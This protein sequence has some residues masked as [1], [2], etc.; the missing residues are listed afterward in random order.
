MTT[1]NQVNENQIYAFAQVDDKDKEKVYE[2][3]H[4][5]KSRFGWSQRD[6][7]DLSNEQNRESLN[8]SK[9]LF[10]TR[11]KKGDWIVHVN[12]PTWGKCVAAM[13][14]GEY[15]FDEG[16]AVE[17]ERNRDFRHYIPIDVNSITEFDRRDAYGTINLAPRGRQHTVYAKADFLTFID[18]IKSGNKHH[19]DDQ[20]YNNTRERLGDITRLINKYHRGK[21]L[22]GFLAKVFRAIPGVLDVKENGKRWGADHGADL[23]VEYSYNNLFLGVKSSSIINRNLRLV[24]QAKSYDGTYTG[25]GEIEQIKEGIDKYNAD[26]GLIINTADSAE[27]LQK[28]LENEGNENIDAIIGEDVASFVIGASP[29]VLFDYNRD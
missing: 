10:L 16:I 12:S 29:D 3:I 6:H 7:N 27:E 26:F 28:E 18:A 17:D 21:E 4:E 24:V 22:E 5:G 19:R 2:Q 20:F 8:N 13:A 15:E 25:I 23:I 1:E 14:I 11:I 9:Q